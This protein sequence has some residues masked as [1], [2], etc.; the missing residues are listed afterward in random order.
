MLRGGD[1]QYSKQLSKKETVKAINLSRQI[2]DTTV[3]S[4]SLS[5]RRRVACSP[6]SRTP[7]SPTLKLPEEVEPE[8]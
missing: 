3:E 2:S 4:A 8:S 1:K 5:S 6:G 7:S